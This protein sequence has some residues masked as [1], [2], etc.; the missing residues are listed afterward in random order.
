MTTI[1]S[2]LSWVVGSCISA[3]L[4]GYWLH[5]LLHS[6]AVGFLSRSH[7]RHHL[8]LY[9][10]R[11]PQRSEEYHDATTGRFAL[12]NI[13]TE[14]LLPAAVLILPT[15]GIFLLL[16]VRPLYEWIYFTT[17]LAWSFL[18]FSELH[19]VMHIQNFWLERTPVLKQWF[20]GARKK[21]DLHHFSINDRGLMDKNFGI[22]FSF[23][24]RLFGTF[25]EVMPGFNQ[26]GYKAAGER[27]KSLLDGK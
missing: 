9:G 11:Q 16:H 21:H 23:F 25:S 7:M 27:F 15:V 8:L 6:G 20:V 5:R 2:A 12:G 10:P 13:G 17:T 18:M 14:W 24:D 4:L 19:D 22:A 26:N 3:E 1:T